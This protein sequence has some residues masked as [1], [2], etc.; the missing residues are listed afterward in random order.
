MSGVSLVQEDAQDIET[1]I[2]K[3]TGE[4]G[5]LVLLGV[6]AFGN[7]S[8]LADRVNA[9]I[10]I[11]ILVREVPAIWRAASN[12]AQQTP[13]HCSDLG[14]AIAPA[15]QGLVVTG[16]QPLRMLKGEPLGNF[17]SQQQKEAGEAVIY[18]DYRLELETMQI[19]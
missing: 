8:P 16:Y 4:V 3:A 19:F 12:T 11:E 2:A 5:M 18:Q 17:I 14:Q 15:L 6:P 7:D 1:E 13:V 10:Q 9:R